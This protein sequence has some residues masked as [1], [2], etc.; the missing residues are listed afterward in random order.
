MNW[1]ALIFAAICAAVAVWIEL[2]FS[3]IIAELDNANETL[4][5]ILD[6]VEK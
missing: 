2:R 4:A 5:S 6:A 1:D 3:R